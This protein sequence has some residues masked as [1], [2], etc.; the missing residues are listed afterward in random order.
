MSRTC[1][2]SSCHATLPIVFLG[3]SGLA[4]ASNLALMP[5]A[6]GLPSLCVGGSGFDEPLVAASHS[7]AA[8]LRPGCADSSAAF[9]CT[10][11]GFG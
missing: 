6:D 5:V 1:S 3:G 7:A 11:S 4:S 2:R 10:S 9:D 8:L